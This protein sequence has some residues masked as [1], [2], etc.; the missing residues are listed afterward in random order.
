M[1]PK[2]LEKIL[3]QCWSRETSTSPEGWTPENPAWGQCAVTALVVQDL[4]G[5][6]LM[7][8][9]LEKVPG[10]EFMRSHY[11]NKLP[12]GRRLDLSKTQF[13]TYAYRDIPRGEARARKYPLSH[14]PTRKRY[15]ILRLAIQN[16]LTPNPIFSDPIYRDC[17][18]TAQMSECKKMRFGCVALHH[19]KTIAEAA[20]TPIKALRHVCEPECIRSRIQSRTESMLG[21]CGHAE[22]W[23]IQEVIQKGI[24]L[25]ATTFYIAGFNLDNTPWIKEKAEHTCLRCATQ[26]HMAGIR[27]IY[28]P[29]KSGW[30]K[31]NPDTYILDALSYALGEKKV[32]S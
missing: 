24:S 16:M 19:G 28:V 8:A 10:F 17:F 23:T 4:F 15:A 22:E 20:N 5:G 12:N 11:W 30:G 27:E 3:K 1:T 7:R 14:E 2:E 26:M 6:E 18:E 31:I 32:N 29:T 25:R 21:A 13:P 9:S